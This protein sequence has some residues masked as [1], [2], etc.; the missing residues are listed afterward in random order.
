[1]SHH[2]PVGNSLKED[3]STPMRSCR[4]GWDKA[5]NKANKGQKENL[6]LEDIPN[7][8]DETEW[9]W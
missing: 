6:L 8:F 1:M 4:E 7:D 3:G 2:V 5:F 9:E